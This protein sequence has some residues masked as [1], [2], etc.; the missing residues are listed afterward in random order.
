MSVANKFEIYS[1]QNATVKG[2]WSSLNYNAV[3]LKVFSENWK[4]L[5]MGSAWCC[6][7]VFRLLADFTIDKDR[8]WK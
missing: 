3:E 4:S 7:N 8:R 1:N 5:Q 6:E 2:S